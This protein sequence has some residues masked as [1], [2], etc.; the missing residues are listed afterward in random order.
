MVDKLE[1]LLRLHRNK[2]FDYNLFT[3]NAH[4]RALLRLKRTVT[5]KKMCGR[6]RSDADQRKSE[7]ML[8]AY[9]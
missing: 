5:Y 1:K 7:R 2:V 3:A 4:Y 8:R 9:A 6:V